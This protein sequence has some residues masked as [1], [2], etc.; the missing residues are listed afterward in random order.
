MP[1]D[2]SSAEA[3]AALKA[4]E[5]AREQNWNKIILEGDSSNIMAAIEGD[6][7]S[8]TSYGN[9][10]A[11]IKRLA[12]GFESFKVRHVF[13]EG[14]RAAHELAKLSSTESFVSNSLPLSILDIQQQQQQQQQQKQ[15]QKQKQKPKPKPKPKQPAQV[16]SPPA[17]SCI[18]VGKFGMEEDV[19]MLKRDKN[20][21]MQEL[22][23]LRQQQQ[24][25]D[26]QLQTV[27]QRVHVMEQRLQQMMSFLAN[28]M[29]SPSF[30]SQLVHQQGESNRQISGGSKKRRLPSQDEEN[31][32]RKCSIALPDGQIV[33]YQPLMNEAAKAM[34]R[35][36][37]NMN[38]PSRLE[39]KLI[40]GN[41][42]LIDN[43]H[44]LQ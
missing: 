21:L 32:A 1:L 18:E 4:L 42:F 20:V 36:I 39:S 41:G 17:K 33:K 35:K 44:T 37:L 13:R 22:V 5:F 15:K 7:G 43:V 34:L 31:L 2:P 8:H 25:T 23:R 19:G 24:T 12:S 6:V 29:Q 14:N 27:G 26:H 3:M 16:Q 40:N 28:A 38:T 30:V 9:I 10:I 11:D